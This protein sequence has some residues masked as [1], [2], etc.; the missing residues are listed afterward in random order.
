MLSVSERED[1]LIHLAGT[2]A[3]ELKSLF[4]LRSSNCVIQFIVKK[5][6]RNCL[7]NK[8]IISYITVHNV[9]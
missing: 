6:D 8:I 2:D 3:Y 7:V 4:V 9:P 5:F 1:S